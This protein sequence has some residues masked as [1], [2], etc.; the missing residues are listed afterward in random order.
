[1][2][3]MIYDMPPVL[4]GSTQRQLQEL[5]NYLVRQA[6]RQG[7]QASGQSNAAGTGT[8][9]QIGGK[10]G[11]GGGGS[12]QSVED[13]IAQAMRRAAALKALIIK[14]GE[15][16]GQ[17]LE[18]AVTEVE[19]S[20]EDL[21]LTVS[22]TYVTT[23]QLGS[24]D[25]TL[26]GTYTAA[27]KLAIALSARLIT[28]DYLYGERVILTDGTTAEGLAH[29]LEDYVTLMDGKIQ[30]GF[31]ANPAHATDPSAPEYIFGIA[32][33]SRLQF[34][35]DVK[36]MNR[37][38]ELVDEEDLPDGDP[39]IAFYELNREQTMGIY[40]SDGW[41]FWIGGKKRGWFDAGDSA[42]HV[43]QETIESTLTQGL[44]T[45]TA[46]DGWGIQYVGA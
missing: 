38:G 44:W 6:R 30:R 18:N 27:A 20:I 29:V 19:G 3:D 15:D 21:A 28:E 46:A 23:S 2:S 24:W 11:A 16:W 12:A 39:G 1:M 35:S 17:E 14:T 43:M 40:A 34:G 7:Q 22:Q 36:Y 37:S 13:A 4:Q 42:L 25:D 26:E 45:T 5:R 9:V 8:V 33:S 32:I 31:I 41:Q 10:G